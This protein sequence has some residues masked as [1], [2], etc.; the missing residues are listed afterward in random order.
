MISRGTAEEYVGQF[1][2]TI[3][4]PRLQCINFDQEGIMNSRHDVGET[5]D[6]SASVGLDSPVKDVLLNKIFSVHPVV[7]RLSPTGEEVFSDL[8]RGHN[9]Y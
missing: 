3:D 8:F 5:L 2:E 7:K 1:Q 4:A 9:T 6:V